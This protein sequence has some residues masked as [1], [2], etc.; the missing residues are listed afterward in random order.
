M[1]RNI[2]NTALPPIASHRTP[3]VWLGRV[4]A[5]L[6]G[7]LPSP[8]TALFGAF[9]WGL[10]MGASA[11]VSLLFGEWQT[12]EKIRLVS[13]LFAAGG[14]LA[15]TPGVYVA[16]LISIGRSRETAFAAVF[17]SLL[18]FTIAFTSGIF[19]MQYRVYY[20]EWHAPALSFIWIIQFVFTVGGALVQFA[21]L[22]LRLYFPIGFI[23]L[24]V[25]GL[26]FVRQP[27]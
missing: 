7:A 18:V 16:R 21:V 3:K 1:H 4:L 2:V 9:T 23:A 6:R 12:P 27:R 26:W 25:A 8:S 11:L 17:V 15:F 24:F 14:A 22:G 13:L 19:S 5:A 10:A 20:A